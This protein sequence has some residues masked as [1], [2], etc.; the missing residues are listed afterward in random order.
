MTVSDRFRG[1]AIRIM[2]GDDSMA[3]ARTLEGVVLDEYT[4]DERMEDL[5]EGLAILARS[6]HALH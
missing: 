5:L 2:D 6:W 1:A 4:G 3:A